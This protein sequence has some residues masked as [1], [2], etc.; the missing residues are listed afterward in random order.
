LVHLDAE[1]DGWWFGGPHTEGGG[2]LA[3]FTGA[4]RPAARATDGAE[5]GVVPRAGRQC[6][7]AP[8]LISLRTIYDMDVASRLMAPSVPL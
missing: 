6:G 3:F 1:A 2:L 5:V 4:Y 7:K 8:P